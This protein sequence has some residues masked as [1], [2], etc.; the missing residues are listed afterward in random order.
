MFR[1]KPSSNENYCDN[2]KSLTHLTKTALY[3]PLRYCETLTLVNF[4]KLKNPAF[5][6]RNNSFHVFKF[7]ETCPNSDSCAKCLS[8]QGNAV[9]L[10]TVRH[11]IIPD[12]ALP[13]PNNHG[14]HNN[15]H[16]NRVVAQVAAISCRSDKQTTAAEIIK[17]VAETGSDVELTTEM[18]QQVDLAAL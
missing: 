5:S 17:V 10:V 18:R 6:Q 9:Q 1:N 11:R 7:H 8:Y 16:S 4:L 14:D 2:Y 13:L 12:T 15:F 3:V